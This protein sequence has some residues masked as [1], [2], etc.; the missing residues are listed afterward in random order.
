M[1]ATST[2]RAAYRRMKKQSLREARMT[3]KL[4]RQQRQDRE[5]REK[6]K[7][8]DYL[9]S[10]VNHGRDMIN[11]HR[12]QQMKQNKLGRLVVQFHSQVEKEEAKRIERISKERLKA[13]KNDDEEAYMK[14]IDQAKDTRITHLLQQTDAY[15]TSLAEAVAAQQNDLVHTDV[16]TRGG[17]EL[18]DD[19]REFE[20][21]EGV[22]CCCF[23]KSS[24]RLKRIEIGELPLTLSP[25]LEHLGG[26]QAQRLLQYRSQ[27]P[28]E[29]HQAA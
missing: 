22:S 18:M 28:G 15:L 1:L 8:M 13:L 4:E 24:H 26:Q 21:G 3:E 9:Q 10:I 2:D 7:H 19:E 12:T 27:D 16:T 23:D 6:Q 29:G 5:G 17:I 11:W 14:L 20:Y 25:L